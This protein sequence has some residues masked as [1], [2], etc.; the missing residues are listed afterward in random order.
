METGTPRVIYGNV[1]NDSLIENLPMECA[2]E[3]P[4][5]VDRNGIQPTAIGAMPP[6]LAAL[7][8]T[9]VNP[10]ILTVEAILTGNRDHVYH[11][12]MMDPHTSAE[13]TLDEI[14]SLVDDLFEAHGDW[15]PDIWD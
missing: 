10:Q 1:L 15:I 13:L 9:N 8:Q 3:V 6:H 12:A 14:H 5:L 2:V 11:A 4:C 7:I